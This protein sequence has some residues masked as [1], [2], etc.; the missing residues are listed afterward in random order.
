MLGKVIDKKGYSI[1]TLANELK[2]SEK[3][4]KNKIEG[5]SEFKVREVLK[6]SILL[7]LSYN[8][9]KDIFFN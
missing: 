9:V 2:I 8:E 3:M 5:K 6:M 4:L 1:R 7:N